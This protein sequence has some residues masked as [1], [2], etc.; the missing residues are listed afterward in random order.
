[1]KILVVGRYSWLR[2]VRSHYFKVFWA[3]GFFVALAVLGTN[4][5]ANT[6]VAKMSSIELGLKVA[7]GCLWLAAIWVGMTGLAQELSTY[8]A[9]TLM[10]KPVR[11]TSMT[12]GI[13]LGGMTYL[14]LLTFIFCLEIHFLGSLRDIPLDGNLYLFQFSIL[15]PLFAIMAMSQTLSLIFSRP[16]TAFLMLGLS[17]ESIWSFFSKA[18]EASDNHYLVKWPLTWAADVIYHL[19]PTY[20]RFI[21]RFGEFQRLSFP[22][23]RFLLH[24]AFCLLFVAVCCLLSAMLLSRKDI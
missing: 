9:R 21:L 10:T 24:S 18:M 22:L 15:P 11:R 13:L 20:G 6:L 7:R 23:E 2:M 16:I 8:T 4:A 1:M 17:Y 3:F 14:T 5:E 12:S 19:T